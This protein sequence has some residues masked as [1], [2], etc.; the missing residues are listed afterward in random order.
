MPTGDIIAQNLEASKKVEN[1]LSEGR[2]Y[3]EIQKVLQKNYGI[4]VSLPVIHGFKWN[5][6]MYS[7]DGPKNCRNHIDPESIDNKCKYLSN[8]IKKLS[9]E[10]GG[11][12]IADKFALMTFY[13][14]R[15]SMIEKELDDVLVKKAR[16]KEDK[17]YLRNLLDLDRKYLS[18]LISIFYSER[19]REEILQLIESIVDVVIKV[20]IEKLPADVQDMCVKDFQL[21]L[22]HII[23]Q[24]KVDMK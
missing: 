1:L 3:Q 20:F 22:R 13:E 12:W 8:K 4:S 16:T 15:L 11:E 17:D 23:D 21:E 18:D 7:P 19:R 24:A 10:E 2:P 6:V 9:K 14:S 5:Y